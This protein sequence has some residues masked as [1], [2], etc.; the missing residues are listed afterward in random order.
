[1][2]NTCVFRMGCEGRSWVVRAKG[3][4]G[5][6]A[7]GVLSICVDSAAN[8]LQDFWQPG[9]KNKLIKR[10]LQASITDEHR[11]I[12]PQQNSSKQNPITY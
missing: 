3:G 4:I 9:I 12:N 7:Y 8:L 11:C 1:M 2:E 6:G 5:N 10:K